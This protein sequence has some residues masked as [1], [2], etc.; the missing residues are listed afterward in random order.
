[1]VRSLYIQVKLIIMTLQ[2]EQVLMIETV[3]I[4]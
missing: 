2:K 4:K 3:L 1:M